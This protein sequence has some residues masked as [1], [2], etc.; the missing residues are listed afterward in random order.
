MDLFSELNN[1]MFKY[2]FAPSRK[3]AQNFVISPVLLEKMVK[4]ADLKKTDTVLEVGAGAGFLTRELLK[5]SK[6]IAVEL[7]NALCK[8]LKK[9]YSKEIESKKLVLIE[10]NFLEKKLPEFNKVVSLPPYTISSP[11]L[12]KLL[13]HRIEKAVL[14]FQREFVLKCLSK[15]GFREF[16]PLAV[17]IDYYFDSRVLVDKV[18]PES[19]F[20]NPK[21][22]SALMVLSG[23]KGVREIK[24]IGLFTLFLKTVFRYKNK[25]LSN[26]LMTSYP[27]LKQQLKLTKKEFEKKVMEL[28]QKDLKVYL[29]ETSE[30]TQIFKKLF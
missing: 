13:E 3:M 24:K 18:S 6:V 10:G 7:D 23:K 4:A 25:N 5:H 19:F 14:V 27:F 16:C 17:L 15:P 11:L 1:L 30:F 8:L 20:P 9:E 29:V 2:G 12:F 22:F 26:A 28:H 21:S